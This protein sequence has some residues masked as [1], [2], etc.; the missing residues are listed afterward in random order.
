M[1]MALLW[2]RTLGKNYYDFGKNKNQISLFLKIN[3]ILKL[4]IIK[5]EYLCSFYVIKSV[6]LKIIFSVSQFLKQ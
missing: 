6:V 5:N 3:T 4:L 1:I 2:R